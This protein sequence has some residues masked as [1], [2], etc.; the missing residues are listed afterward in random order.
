MTYLSLPLVTAF[1]VFLTGLLP[2]LRF[3]GSVLLLGAGAV[4]V[5]AGGVVL[6]RERPRTT[7][8]PSLPPA[9][10]VAFALAGA[11][12]GAGGNRAARDDCR[13]RFPEGV[14]LTVRGVLGADFRGATEDDPV[15]LLPLEVTEVRAGRELI[16]GCGGE[17]RVR[18]PERTAPMLA[19]AEVVARG[20]WS[21]SSPP[22][23]PSAWPRDPSFAGFLELRGITG[24]TPP[25]LVAHPLLTL[26][27][28]AEAH[29]YRVF[30]AHASLAD[31]LVLG[32]REG[33]DPA[34]NT[35][36]AQSGLVHLLAISGGHVA[37]LAGVLLLLGRALRV[38]R[39]PVIWATIALMTL[40]LAVIGA[41]ASAVRSGIMV[42]LGLAAILLQ[43][44]SAALPVVAASA[45]VILAVNP[46]SVLDPGFQL[47]YAGVL[48]ILLLR[49]AMMKRIP[50]VWRHG[51]IGRL[52]VEPLVVSV[53]A[54][55]ATAPATA[56]Q[57]GQVA[58]ISILANLPAIPLTSLALVGIGAGALTEPLVPPLGHLFADGT[59]LALDLLSR[60][61]SFA[62][63][64]PW[65]HHAV[66]PPQWGLWAVVAAAVLLALDAG[67]RMR[68]AVR[69]A[70]AMGAAGAAFLAVP[71]LAASHDTGLEIHFLDV[72][73]GDA[74]AIRTPA[75]RWILVDAGPRGEHFDA[76][77]RR[78]LPFLREHG[79]SRLEALVVT[80]PD[81]DHI[82]GAPAV[83]RGVEVGR[84]VEP[85]LAVGK[86]LYLETLHTAQERGTAWVAARQ[87]RTLSL[88]GVTLAF[89]WPVQAM[90]DANPEANKISAV[91]QLRYGSFAALLTG[92]ADTEVEG[93]LVER[94]GDSL[95]SQV[96]KVGHH[97]SRTSTSDAL[98][99][100]VRPELAA[101]SVGRR[102]RYGHPTPETLARLAAHH[103][104]VVRTDREGTVSIRVAGGGN[105]GWRRIE[106]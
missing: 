56:A 82:G 103:V 106:P 5:L 79:V 104:P 40:Y 33:L 44:P 10:L 63:S 73:Q 102:N 53:A 28:R 7:G 15:P 85:G 55:V 36:F 90:L 3:G 18:L 54:F 39:V 29:L 57:F 14:R 6:G 67:A 69:W 84:L 88:D 58:P 8:G 97:G 31:A 75:D 64:V 23:T 50:A 62:A 43:R 45:L 98:L 24:S 47:S 32:R 92:D 74:I 83:L 77:E 71:A 59:G 38:P 11:A 1:L 22:V 4:L 105:S 91:M 61:A 37:L 72:G 13:A 49:G 87:G 68:A 81:A 46:A 2:G 80:H 78:V 99:D 48:G 19:G 101:V 89:L 20:V 96:L 17:V 70:V 34:L 12:L 60:V 100:A 21:R 41:P 86:P 95:R 27:G 26:R 52:L 42:G 65:G 66:A 16:P 94:Y 51:R 9:L 35:V 30:G 93:R 25:S 76:G